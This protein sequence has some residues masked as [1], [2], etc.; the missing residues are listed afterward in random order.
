MPQAGRACPRKSSS[1]RQHIAVA[2]V[3]RTG[4]PAQE[5]FEKL[6]PLRQDGLSYSEIARR[7]GYEP[8]FEFH[9]RQCGL[10]AAPG[11]TRA[12]GRVVI[13]TFQD[14]SDQKQLSGAWPRVRCRPLYCL[15]ARAPAPARKA[16]GVTSQEQTFSRRVSRPALLAYAGKQFVELLQLLRQCGRRAL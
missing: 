7:T 6:H 5:I 15:T 2:P 3:S 13:I 10:D 12:I 1:T 4:N 11:T 8:T 9:S 16:G 14:R